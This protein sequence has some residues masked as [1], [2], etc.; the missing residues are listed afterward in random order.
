GGRQ[1]GADAT[2]IQIEIEPE[3]IGVNRAVEVGL[4]GDA[5]AIVHQVLA[6]LEG[7]TA[8]MAERAE[9][10][11]WLAMLRE[12][13]HKNAAALEPLLHS[14]ATPIRTHRL[15]HEVREL[16]PRETIYTVCWQTPLAAGRQVLQRYTP[17]SRLNSGS[18]GCM[19]V[20]VPFA[21]GAKLARPA[22]PVVS[23]NGDCAFGFNCMEMETAVRHKLPIVFVVNNNS[24][25][26]GGNLEAR[27]GL[28][29]GTRSGLPLTRLTFV[30]TKSWRPL[31]VIRSMSP[32]LSR[33]DRP[34]SGLCRPPGRGR[35][36]VSM[37]S[38]TPW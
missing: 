30:M 9:D 23:V 8:G 32:I 37:S 5:R 31:A 4:I 36:P 19:G 14:T 34:W 29:M 26:V 22:V 25:I 18:N 6:E 11:A 1:S 16:L 35:W 15:L 38:Q 3:E 10:S 7:Q 24:G 21:V 13:A 20:G 28:P 27:M 12:Q 17:A 2:I 33:S